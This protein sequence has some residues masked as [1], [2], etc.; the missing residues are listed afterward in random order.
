MQAFGA[1]AAGQTGLMLL[2][3]SDRSCQ[4]ISLREWTAYSVQILHALIPALD[5]LRYVSLWLGYTRLEEGDLNC[6]A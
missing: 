5:P 2:D 1:P 3:L 6:A 4:L